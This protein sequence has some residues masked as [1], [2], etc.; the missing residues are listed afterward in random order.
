MVYFV[1]AGAGDPELLT[2]KEKQLLE[3][4]TMLQNIGM[5]GEWIGT[6]T[7]EPT[8]YFTTL[9]IRHPQSK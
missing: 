8:S 7:A 5:E 4:T 2:V 9:I 1:G 6:P 3:H